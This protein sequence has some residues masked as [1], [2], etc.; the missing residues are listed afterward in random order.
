VVRR[1]LEVPERCCGDFGVPGDAGVKFNFGGGEGSRGGEATGDAGVKFKFGGGEGSRGEVTGLTWV[2]V[3][4]GGGGGGGSVGILGDAGGGSV[5]RE[6]RGRVEM[7]R[8]GVP[9]VWV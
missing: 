4:G 7:G 9:G 8:S 3:G 5:G 1:G 2:W 6:S